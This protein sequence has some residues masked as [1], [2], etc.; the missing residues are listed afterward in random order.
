[1]RLSCKKLLGLG[2]ALAMTATI[3]P[4]GVT[5]AADVVTQIEIDPGVTNY[6]DGDEPFIT[7]T[8]H[9]GRLEINY[10]AW[11]CE[12]DKTYVMG[13]DLSDPYATEGYSKF[14]KFEAGKT[15]DY[16]LSAALKKST[17]SFSSDV[18]HVVFQDAKITIT[19]DDSYY[20]A[21]GILTT[22]TPGTEGGLSDI[23]EENTINVKKKVTLKYKTKKQTY[24]LNASCAAASKLTYQSNN[25]KIKVNAAGKVTIPAKW[26]GTVKITVKSPEDGL[27]Q[28]SKAVV[29][30]KVKK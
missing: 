3:I 29:T 23:T 12:A 5:K 21:T 2:L 22:I 1:M 11:V 13:N 24:K 25:K 15:Y 4:A 14:E 18:K 19:E 10:L 9:D 20:Y 28:P 30:I 6:A 17:G 27:Y 7:P 16:V 8:I 26:K